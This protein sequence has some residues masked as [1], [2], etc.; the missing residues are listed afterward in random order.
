MSLK[1]IQKHEHLCISYKQ[2]L[3][4]IFRIYLTTIQTFG[5]PESPIKLSG[6]EV[7]G[8]K[9]LDI[10]FIASFQV[11]RRINSMTTYHVGVK[12]YS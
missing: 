2:S 6:I 4:E 7:W 8:F 5:F 3:L 1:S 9:W 10:L 11:N 12:G